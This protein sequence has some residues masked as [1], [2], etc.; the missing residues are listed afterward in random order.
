MIKYTNLSL[1]HINA[2]FGKTRVPKLRTRKKPHISVTVVKTGLETRAGSNF[3]LLRISG[4]HP[5][6]RTDR[7]V[8]IMS[9]AATTRLK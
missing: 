2:N 8:L 3:A 5:P 6:R 9:E 1:S 7:V 4:R